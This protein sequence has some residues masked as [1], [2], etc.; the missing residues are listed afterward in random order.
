MKNVIAAFTQSPLQRAR[1]SV[2]HFRALLE[3]QENAR[4]ALEAKRDAILEAMPEGDTRELARIRDSLH[5]IGLKITETRAGLALAE[6]RESEAQASAEADAL[7]TR[8][9]QTQ[10][11]CERR[12]AAA[13]R[14][15]SHIAAI[16]AAALE[17]EALTVEL[18]GVAPIEKPWRVLNEWR[19]GVRGIFEQQ[20]TIATNG[21]LGDRESLGVYTVIEHQQRGSPDFAAFIAG[22][23]RQIL[24][25]RT[26]TKGADGNEPAAA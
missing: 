3:G 6:R 13:V 15:Q 9:K 4:T 19:E 14:I 10:S 2:A 24:V 1:A 21:A 12:A 8:W 5:E 22:Q 25:N 7:A 26:D 18:G 20:I 16:A 23:H 17:M 11:A